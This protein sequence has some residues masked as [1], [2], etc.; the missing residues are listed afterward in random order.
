MK[1]YE[2]VLLLDPTIEDSEV[3]NTFNSVLEILTAQGAEIIE[4]DTIDWGKRKLAFPLKKKENAFYRIYRFNAESEALEQIE[5][6]LKI[7]D[8]V[9]R[10]LIVIYDPDTE[11]VLAQKPAS[12]DDGGKK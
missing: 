6:R 2:I 12:G 9:I 11:R 5:R 8:I 7:N 10:S 4:S 3:D 1:K